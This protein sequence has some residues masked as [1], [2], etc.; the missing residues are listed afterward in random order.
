M[1]RYF[2]LEY[3]TGSNKKGGR[4]Q[5]DSPKVAAHNIAKRFGITSNTKFCIRETT[6]DSK[7]KTYEYKAI[8]KNGIVKISSANRKTK[9]QGGWVSIPNFPNIFRLKSLQKINSHTMKSLYLN[10]ANNQLNYVHNKGD[11]TLFSIDAVRGGCILYIYDILH[12]YIQSNEI[13]YNNNNYMIR[14][15]T[16]IAP[17]AQHNIFKI[18]DNGNNRFSIINSNGGIK[19]NVEGIT[20]NEEQELHVE[21][22]KRAKELHNPVYLLP[23]LR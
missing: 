21:K 3:V 16:F 19:F 23:G 8:V 5:A 14:G 13:Y 4:Y 11:A 20:T 12:D 15:D 7:K 10:F 6:K 17:E 2:T 1:E 18:I 22:Q 9:S